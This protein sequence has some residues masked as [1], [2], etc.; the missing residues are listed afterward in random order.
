MTQICKQLLGFRSQFKSSSKKDVYH[1]VS[2]NK[3]LRKLVCTCEGFLWHQHCKHI[4]EIVD[5][6]LLPCDWIGI[7]PN[8][9][10]PK[11]GEKVYPIEDKIVSAKVTQTTQLP[12]YELKLLKTGKFIGLYKDDQVYVFDSVKYQDVIHQI[13][14]DKKIHV[15]PIT[16]ST[17]ETHQL[18]KL[19]QDL[20]N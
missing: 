12:T 5:F 19:L 18:I 7:S 6:D 15:S 20:I 14:D 3:E 17:E 4:K 10:C 8:S 16:D 13:I 2:Y 11:C 9:I 1:V